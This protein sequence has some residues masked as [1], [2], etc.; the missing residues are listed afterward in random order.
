MIVF[1]NKKIYLICPKIDLPGQ[2]EG[3]QTLSY[4]I[5]RRFGIEIIP[6]HALEPIFW[7]PRSRENTFWSKTDHFKKNYAKPLRQP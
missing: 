2:F 6:K 1:S 5:L 4:D 3:F 7:A